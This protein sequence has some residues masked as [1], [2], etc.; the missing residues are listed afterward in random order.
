MQGSSLES[1][2]KPAYA[3]QQSTCPRVWADPRLSAAVPGSQEQ[4]R[5]PRLVMIVNDDGLVNDDG[6][7]RPELRSSC[8]RPPVMLQAAAAQCQINPNSCLR[9]VFNPAQVI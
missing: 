1:C 5:Y 9:L 7:V 6:P 3:L 4:S 2:P 8:A